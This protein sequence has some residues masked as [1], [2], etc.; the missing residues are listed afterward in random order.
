M[1]DGPLASK[2]DRG[3]MEKGN[4]ISNK[5]VKKNKSKRE[6]TEEKETENVHMHE[7]LLNS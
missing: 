6:R 4:K 5:R 7:E 3:E 1:S 2:Q